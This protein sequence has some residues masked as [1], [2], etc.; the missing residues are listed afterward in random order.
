MA[1][2][3]SQALRL[4]VLRAVEGGMS[5]HAAATPFGLSRASAVRGMPT[6]LRS[7]RTPAT[8]WGGDRPSGRLDAQADL[9]LESLQPT[10]DLT[11]AQ[12]R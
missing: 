12:L 5:R 8:P 3:L 1:A 11:R 10:P 9:S 7:R 4:R 2:D 6:S